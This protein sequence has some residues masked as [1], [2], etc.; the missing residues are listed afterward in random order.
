[1]AGRNNNP[2]D[3]RRIGLAAIS[4]NLLDAIAMLETAIRSLDSDDGAGPEIVVLERTL[5][6]LGN[7]SND[8]DRHF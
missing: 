5:R 8:L 3:G 7:V 2:G 4:G 1:M 6:D